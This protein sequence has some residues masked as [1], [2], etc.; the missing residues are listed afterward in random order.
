[1]NKLVS[2]LYRDPADASKAVHHLIS[3]GYKAHDVGVLARTK[4]TARSVLGEKVEKVSFHA[5]GDH[6]VAAGCLVPALS[7]EPGHA[8][9]FSDT[10]A[11]VL[12][13]GA[14][15]AEYFEFGLGANGVLVV[16]QTDESKVTEAHAILGQS[17]AAP[18]K[19]GVASPGFD[20]ASR[21]S[22]TNPVDATMTGDFRKY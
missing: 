11:Q 12:G 14:E 6:M 13:V 21:M 20:K 2:R 9:K 3:S 8:G 5:V 19:V 18:K 22:A 10:L 1:M 16:V 4:N 15:A 7:K 17:A